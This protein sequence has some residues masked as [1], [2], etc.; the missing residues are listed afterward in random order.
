MFFLSLISNNMLKKMKKL[1]KNMDFTLKLIKNQKNLRNIFLLKNTK[2]IVIFSRNINREISLI[3]I[4]AKNK[5]LFYL[6]PKDI[7]LSHLTLHESNSLRLPIHPLLL[8]SQCAK[9][10]SF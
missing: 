10:F 5:F 9:L 2:T 6:I 1:K 3:P 4:K 8:Y 7:D